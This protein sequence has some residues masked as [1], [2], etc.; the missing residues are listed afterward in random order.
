MQQAS[1]RPINAVQNDEKSEVVTSYSLEAEQGLLGALMY[2]N[3]GIDRVA[4]FLDAAHFYHPTHAKIYDAIL[5]TAERGDIA[6]PTRLKKYFEKE[7]ALQAVGGTRYLVE[8]VT[9]ALHI[10]PPEDYARQ[11]FEHFMARSLIQQCEET[12]FLANHRTIDTTISDL[13]EVHESRLYDL[14]E[15]GIAK[16]DAV[17]FK[18][19]VTAAIRMA[20]AAYNR[21]GAVS[22]VTTGLSELDRMLGG[23]H[24]TDLIIL[25]GRPSMGKTAL[26]TNIAFNAAKRSMQTSGGEGAAVGFFSLEMGHAQIT[27]RILGDLCGVSSDAMRKGSIT[28]E[29]FVKLVQVGQEYKDLPFYTDDTAAL[30]I[31]ALRTRARRMKRKYGISLLVVDYLQLLNGTP[32][33]KSSENRTQEVSEITRGLKSIA[34]DLNIPVLALSQLS[35]NLESRED[36]RPQLSD[37]RESGSIEQDSDV[38]MFVY[39]DEYYLSREEPS[40]RVNETIEKFEDRRGQWEQALNASKNV[41]DVL[42]SKQRHGPIGNV[43][44]Y[45]DPIFTRFQNLA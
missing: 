12:R 29:D 11:I 26:A 9:E 43:K 1:A 19:S 2:D 27:T 20:E 36:K 7:E 6:S 4:D 41:T 10:N 39:R 32:G 22:G 23:M 24:P 14:A 33:R 40:Q 13:I 35:R 42:I 15:S 34:K 28:H 21:G 37:L 18:D 38:V 25:A 44:L 8:L 3:A 30:S 17:S 31:S 45:F 16:K 5:K